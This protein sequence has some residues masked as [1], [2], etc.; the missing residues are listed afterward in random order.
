MFSRLLIPIRERVLD[1]AAPIEDQRVLDVGCGDGLIA[2]GALERGAATVVFSDISANLLRECQRR[3]RAGGVL[4]RCTFVQA[5][6]ENLAAIESA[7]MDIV[8]TRSVLIYVRDKRASFDEFA[9]VLRPGGRLSMFEPINR[10]AQREWTGTRFFGADIEPVAGL[11]EKIRRVYEPFNW[12]DDPMHDFDERDLVRHAEDAGFEPIELTLRAEVR[13]AEPCGWD[14]F[15]NTAG[16]PNIPTPAEAM[17][18][19]LTAD[20]RDEFTTY[21]RPLVESGQRIHR[22]AHAYLRAVRP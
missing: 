3:A 18:E 11:A 9:R 14:V 1:G 15:L 2:F 13:P 21:L 6:A 8:T 17:A 4:E 12:A 16:N 19:A 7:S 20:E 5:P 10:F 22:M